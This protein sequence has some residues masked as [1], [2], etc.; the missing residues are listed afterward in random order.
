[1]NKDPVDYWLDAAEHDLD[2]AQLLFVNEKYDYCLFIGHLVIE[3]VL[4][5]FYMQDVKETPPKIHN[6]LRLAESTNLRLTDDQKQLL[7]EMNRFNIDARYPDY[8]GTFHKIC[9]KEF[10]MDY[11]TKIKGLYEWLVYQMKQS[12]P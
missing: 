3:K 5:A 6:L 12:R 11:F 9:T 7:A 10:A 1:M 8:K 2:V 4:K